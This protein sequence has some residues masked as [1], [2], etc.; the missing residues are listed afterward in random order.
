MGNYKECPHYNDGYCLKGERKATGVPYDCIRRNDCPDVPK[1]EKVEDVKAFQHV[2]IEKRQRAKRHLANT[3]VVAIHPNGEIRHFES[4]YVAAEAY[5]TSVMN[6]QK[7]CLRDIMRRYS[8]LNIKERSVRFAY[9]D[10][11]DYE[12]LAKRNK[13]LWEKE[14]AL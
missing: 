9:A 1:K 10:C 3:P 2:V 6:I 4:I 11:K 5:G 7:N 14:N 12:L 13:E 8:T